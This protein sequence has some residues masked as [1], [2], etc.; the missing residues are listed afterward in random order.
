MLDESYRP[1]C[2]LVA[3]A[4]TDLPAGHAIEIVGAR[5]ACP[6]SSRC[7]SRLSRHKDQ[8]RCLIIW[9]LDASSAAMSSRGE[10]ITAD[11]VEPTGDSSSV[12]VAGRTGRAVLARVIC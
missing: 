11:A 2:D 4:Q 1:V 8:I 10:F 12:E 7:S 3:K 6:G 9:W 5:H